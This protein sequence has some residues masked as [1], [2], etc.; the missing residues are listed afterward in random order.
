MILKTQKWISQLKTK[1]STTFR[2]LSWNFLPDFSLF[3]IF[4]MRRHGSAT[5]SQPREQSSVVTPATR[6]VTLFC[7]SGSNLESFRGSLNG[8]TR[9]ACWRI[10]FLDQMTIWLHVWKNALQNIHQL[11]FV[12]RKQQ[13]IRNNN[14][15][16]KINNNKSISEDNTIHRSLHQKKIP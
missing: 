1:H 5:T 15:K 7:D 10:Q 3:N 14:N 8:W 9:I 16:W 4:L 11:T 2:W 12:G 13:Q 6:F